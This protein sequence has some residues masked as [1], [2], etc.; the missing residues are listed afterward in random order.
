MWPFTNRE[1]R[2]KAINDAVRNE[3]NKNIYLHNIYSGVPIPFEDNPE[4]QLEIGYMDNVDV[5]SIINYVARNSAAV[6]LRVYDKDDEIVDDHPIMEL[7]EQPNPDMSMVDIIEAFYIYKLSIGNS[8]LYK[9]TLESGANIGK[10]IEILVMPSADVQAIGGTWTDPIQGYRINEGLIWNTIDK[11]DIY[12]GKFF[13]PKFSNGSWLYGLSP[14][15]IAVE[16]IRTQN[17]G[18]TALESAYL[19]GSPPYMITHKGKNKLTFTQQENLEETFKRKY[20]DGDDFTKPGS[21]FTKPMLTSEDLDIKMIGLS[22]IDLNILN[23]NKQGGRTLANVLGG[24]PT[25]LLND[26]ENSTYSNYS[27][28]RKVF[29]ENVVI[30]NN[31]PLQ[32]GLTNWLLTPYNDGTKFKFDYSD[33]GPLQEDIKEKTEALK[34]AYYLT[35]NERRDQL[36]YPPIQGGDVISAA[37]TSIQQADKE[38]EKY[39]K[40]LK[41]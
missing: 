20:G 8:Y 22:P 38:T 11:A 9:P 3:L 5:Y 18:Y 13:N 37:P 10:T 2:L 19:N 7:L 39:L 41:L 24:I 27:E 30:P 12:H 6:P 15:K 29:Y 34:N 33:I 17:Y 28:A 23:V 36:N 35:I 16:L 40:S 26:L 31:T 32:K 14:I 4:T 1:Q 21:N 25:V